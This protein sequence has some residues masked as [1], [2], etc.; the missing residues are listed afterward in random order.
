MTP[1]TTLAKANY[2]K[3]AAPQIDA[4]RSYSQK[5]WDKSVVPQLLIAQN[6]ATQLYNANLAPHVS[7]V[8]DAASPYY[9]SAKDTAEGVR[10]NHIIPA[11][12][13]SKPLLENA[14][15]TSQHFVLDTAYPMAWTA[16][17]RTAI[18][19]DGTLWPFMKGL[20][21]DNV[22]PQLV[23][24]SERIAKYQESRKLQ[25]VMDE[26]EISPDAT[27]SPASPTPAQSETATDS[28]LEDMFSWDDESTATPKPSASAP[29]PPPKKEPEWATEEGIKED[30]EKWEKKFGVAADKGADDLREHMLLRS[31]LVWPASD[32]DGV[33]RTT[34]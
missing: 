4:A 3:F 20:Y 30:L 11:V 12:D 21:S 13:Y 5:Q 10:K 7:K 29:P 8:S 22:R 17:T 1:A 28:G 24:I 14:Y 25:A 23:M 19:V 26:A 2:V 9:S 34:G 15:S 6:R 18:F 31:C 33:G 16:Y 27:S 32:I